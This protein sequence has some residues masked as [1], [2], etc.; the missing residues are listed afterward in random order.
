MILSP[1][2]RPIARRA[3]LLAALALAIIVTLAVAEAGPFDDDRPMARDDPRAARAIGVATEVVRGRPVAVAR[4]GDD[5][6]W[7]ITVRSPEGDY[8]VE[9]EPV[10]LAL[11]GIDYD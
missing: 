4:D 8:E 5:G 6:R 1:R 3:A 11:R 7:E 9:L 10:S 2:R